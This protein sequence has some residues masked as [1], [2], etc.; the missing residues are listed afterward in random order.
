MSKVEVTIRYAILNKSSELIGKMENF[1]HAT[2]NNGTGGASDF[3]TKI[4]EGE[5][6]KAITW[7]ETFSVPLR[8]N[9]GSQIEFNVMDE[10]M[11][12]NDICGYGFFRLDSCGVFNSNYPQKYNIRLIREKTEE[13]AGSL[14]IST[15]FV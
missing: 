4:I 12:S 13:Q 11:T 2:V 15:R 5:K 6:D 1:V 10:D 7:N 9:T 14:H 8:P 3:K